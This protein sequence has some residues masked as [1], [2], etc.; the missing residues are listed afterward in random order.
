[1]SFNISTTFPPLVAENCTIALL[2]SQERYTWT[3]FLK[4]HCP[5]ALSVDRYVT[6]L[7]YIIGLVGNTLA[8]MIW[9]QR[10]MR[11]NNSSAVYLATLSI[12]DLIFLLF[13]TVQE[14]KYAWEVNTL[15]YPVVCEGYFMLYLVVQYLSPLLVLGFTVE[16][17]IAICHP[18]QKEEYCT[19][20]RATKVVTGFIMASLLLCV[21]Q[22]YFWT[23]DVRTNACNMRIEVSSGYASLWSV[24]TWCT[25]SLIFLLVPVVILLFNILVIREVR[26]I[27]KSGQKFLPT[28]PVREDGTNGQKGH[29]AGGAGR[30]TTVMLLSVSFYVIFTTLPA[31]IVYALNF[32]QGSLCFTD[33]ALQ[34]DPTWTRYLIYLTTRKVVEEICLSHYACNFFLY[35]I[36]GEQFRKC[37]IKLVWCARSRAGD[38]Q[39]GIYHQVNRKPSWL[40]PPAPSNM[41]SI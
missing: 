38:N 40:V 4:V 31:T 36:T 6:P 17:W 37:L 33:E 14:L 23:Y 3:G 8:A 27:A 20:S 1:M 2:F 26:R 32:E 5:V 13:H 30:A 25:E 7:W 9:L 39:N 19:T 34:A 11:V 24:W 16:R 15:D 22:A 12:T 28:A 41:T 35:L 21:I 18:F 10:E 29:S